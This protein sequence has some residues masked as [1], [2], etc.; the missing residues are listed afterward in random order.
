[1]LILDRGALPAG[2]LWRS[3]RGTWPQQGL[4]RCLLRPRK[5]L[6]SAWAVSVLVTAL[7][8]LGGTFQTAAFLAL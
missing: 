7:V 1:M 2:L 5:P 6:G 4:G 8:V 3:R